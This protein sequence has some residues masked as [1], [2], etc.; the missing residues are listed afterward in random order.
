MRNWRTTLVGAISA[1]VLAIQPILE[2]VQGDFSQVNWTQLAFAAT[3]A[4]LGYLT[5]DAGVSGT[6]K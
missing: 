3:L 4:L 2:L 6:Q 5:K 1:V